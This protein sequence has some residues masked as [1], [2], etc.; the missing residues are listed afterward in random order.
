MSGPVRVK[1]RVV[2]RLGLHAR[3]AT[4][5]VDIAAGF[6]SR[7]TVRKEDL[8]VDGKSIMQIMMLAAT[9][10]TDLEIECDGPDAPEC[11]GALKQL[12]DDG[13]DEE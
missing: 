3:P 6:K 5:F 11:A 13:F 8:E 2:N 12:V 4:A 1:A 10:G 9:Q 7:V